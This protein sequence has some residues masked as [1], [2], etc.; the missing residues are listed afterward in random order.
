DALSFSL[1][2]AFRG[3]D[4]LGEVLRSVGLRGSE[5][6]RRR[7]G[8]CRC[9]RDRRRRAGGTTQ[10]L[11]ALATELVGRR[12]GGLASGTE[13]LESRSALPAELGVRGIGVPALGTLHPSTNLPRFRPVGVA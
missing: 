1:Q 10:P 13:R 2:G 8:G 5:A 6:V 11:A 7:R 12:V 3:E 4:L 9:G